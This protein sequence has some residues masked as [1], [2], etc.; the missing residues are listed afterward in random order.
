MPPLLATFA[1]EGAFGLGAAI[2][3][4]RQKNALNGTIRRRVEGRGAIAVLQRR[5]TPPAT[6]STSRRRFSRCPC[7][8]RPITS[9][10]ATA[11]RS[12]G[13]IRFWCRHGIRF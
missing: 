7:G 2:S 6:L 9:L 13:G 4:R 10:V 1:A 5:A 12:V 8:R 3:G 11:S